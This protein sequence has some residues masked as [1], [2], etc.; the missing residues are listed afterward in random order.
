MLGPLGARD[1]VVQTESGWP[2]NSFCWTGKRLAY[3]IVLVCLQRPT[4][5]GSIIES[6]G[7]HSRAGRH[8]QRKHGSKDPSVGLSGS[9][10]RQ[11]KL[12]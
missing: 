7:L 5:R 4:G 10:C 6:A 1:G 2:A 12:L 3:S 11:S 9:V 8:S